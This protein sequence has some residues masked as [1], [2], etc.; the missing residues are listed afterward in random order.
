MCVCPAGKSAQP[1]ERP[2]LAT[3][4]GL[5]KTRARHTVD[6]LGLHINSLCA[7]GGAPTIACMSYTQIFKLPLR[8]V[9]LHLLLA[10]I[11]YIVQTEQMLD[12][13]RLL[14]FR[15]FQGPQLSHEHKSN[16]LVRTSFKTC[17]SA[18]S[19]T[20]ILSC[21]THLASRPS[22]AF[23]DKKDPEWLPSE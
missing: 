17:C 14:H 11:V 21:S 18:P 6:T 15:A 3:N 7:F 16:S 1:S 22:R 19:V 20:F 5:A 4:K 8:H 2:G 23:S 13:L 10:R 12:P 9:A